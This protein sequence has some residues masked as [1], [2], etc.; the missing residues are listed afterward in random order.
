MEINGNRLKD[1]ALTKI[2]ILFYNGKTNSFYSLDKKI[3]IERKNIFPGIKKFEKMLLKCVGW[4][5]AIVYS[6]ETQA[7]IKEFNN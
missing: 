5:K 7:I 2:W 4:K 1:K 3:D 6:M